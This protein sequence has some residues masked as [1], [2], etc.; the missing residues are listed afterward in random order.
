MLEALI[1]SGRKA[2]ETKP[3]DFRESGVGITK[4]LSEEE[5]RTWRGEEVS[6]AERDYTDD[7]TTDDDP[8]RPRTPS[9][10]AIPSDDVSSEDEVE[11]SLMVD[12][13]AL[14]ASG[15]PPITVTPSPS[16]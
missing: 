5:A 16:P 12:E 3:E 13:D 6:F 1:D 2:L 7:G 15:V 4:V 14:S 8:S 11:R 9:R 10:I